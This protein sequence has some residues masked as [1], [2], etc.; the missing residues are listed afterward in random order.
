MSDL[1][2]GPSTCGTLRWMTWPR[3]AARNVAQRAVTVPLRAIGL[4][5]L[6]SICGAGARGATHYVSTYE[7]EPALCAWKAQQA[8]DQAQEGDEVIL[9]SGS[10]H[11]NLILKKGVNLSGSERGYVFLS[12]FT[13]GKPVLTL[14]WNNAVKGLAIYGSPYDGCGIYADVGAPPRKTGSFTP[15]RIS[16]CAIKS[17]AG[18]GILV[19]ALQQLDYDWL[20]ESAQTEDEVWDAYLAASYDTELQVQVSACEITGCGGSG[21]VVYIKGPP[22]EHRQPWPAPGP[23]P[24]GPFDDPFPGPIRVGFRHATLSVSDS[25][26]GDC[27]EKGVAVDAGWYGSAQVIMDRCTVRD[28]GDDGVYVYSL[29]ATSN[30]AVARVTRSLISGNRGTGIFAMS[31]DPLDWWTPYWPPDALSPRQTGK[32]FASSCTIAGNTIGINNWRFLRNC[33]VYAN[34]I[35]DMAF[36]WPDDPSTPFGEY[37][38]HCCTSWG[39]I[40]GGWGNIASDPLFAD[41]ENGDYTLLPGSPCIDAGGM[42][43]QATV[44]VQDATVKICW[45]AGEDLDGNPRIAGSGPDMGAYEVVSEAP[46]YLLESSTDLVNWVEE[47]FGP[48]TSWSAPRANSSKTKFYRVRVGR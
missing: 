27:G 45:D 17:C 2:A 13:P 4:M 29:G 36:H 22:G 46:N 37:I 7:C 10:Y 39:A 34:T 21:I 3:F 9:A 30:G 26:I 5:L 32:V 20:P 16:N 41:P 12:G 35:S 25:T 47:Y 6:L 19:M 28:N 8:I 14:T 43:F 40:H 15:F 48:A 44:I 33:I 38:S 24:R 11:G 23:H 31:Y 42:Y 18:A 1:Q